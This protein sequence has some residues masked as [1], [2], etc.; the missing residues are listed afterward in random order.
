MLNE[1]RNR[2]H[3]ESDDAAVD[4]IVQTS[5]RGALALVGIAT[6]VV[7]G[8]WLAFYMLVFLQRAAAP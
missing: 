3:A 7:I 4:Q 8:I 2:E 6:A 5:A 1:N